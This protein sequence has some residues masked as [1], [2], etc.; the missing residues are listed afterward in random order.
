M[1]APEVE[2]NSPF[3]AGRGWPS[4]WSSATCSAVGV[5]TVVAVGGGVRVG[6]DSVVGLGVGVL[7]GSDGVQDPTS[8]V[9][10]IS[11]ANVQFRMDMFLL[12]S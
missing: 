2:N 3:S 7:V 4:L 5:T 8:S 10:S 6:R 9:K 11:N 12:T 1:Q